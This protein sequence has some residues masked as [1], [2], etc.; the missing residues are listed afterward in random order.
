MNPFYDPPPGSYAF[1]VDA[2]GELFFIEVTTILHHTNDLGLPV[3]LRR[4]NMPEAFGPDVHPEVIQGLGHHIWYY[5]GS[6]SE[7]T[8][9]TA[10]RLYWRVPA[11]GVTRAVIV[12]GAG[13]ICAKMVAEL[14]RLLQKTYGTHL[15]LDKTVNRSRPRKKKQRAEE[16]RPEEQRLATIA[17]H[18]IAQNVCQMVACQRV[19]VS[20][21]T[22]RKYRDL[23]WLLSDDDF[24]TMWGK[25]IDEAMKEIPELAR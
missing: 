13:E 19:V 24:F 12:P 6:I 1:T 7:G 11:L 4:A 2:D 10:F 3:P 9:A 14:V 25:T 8:H 17:H 18:I 21:K 16:P 5:V 22:Y 20:A 15:R 23:T